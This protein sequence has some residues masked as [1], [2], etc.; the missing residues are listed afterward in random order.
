MSTVDCIG[1]LFGKQKI[2]TV[3]SQNNTKQE[4]QTTETLLL[5]TSYATCLAGNKDCK[6][7]V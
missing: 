6:M 5:N 7:S 3:E 2:E 4:I 1:G